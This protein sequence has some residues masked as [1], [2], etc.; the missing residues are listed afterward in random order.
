MLA[1]L[2]CITVWGSMSIGFQRRC[3]SACAPSFAMT[4]FVG[5]KE[6]CLCDTG[7]GKWRRT[8]VDP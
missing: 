6:V 4:P 5:M 2:I 3:E 8:D 1:G 7:N